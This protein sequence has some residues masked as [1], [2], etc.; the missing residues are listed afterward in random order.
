M[1]SRAQDWEIIDVGEYDIFYHVVPTY[2]RR[3][4]LTSDCPC[5]VEMIISNFGDVQAIH[6]AFDGRELFEIELIR[7]N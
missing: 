4:H 7:D 6:N 5:N 2:D 3:P 1:D